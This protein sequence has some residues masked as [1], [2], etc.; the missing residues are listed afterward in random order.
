M[1]YTAGIAQ[2]D[3]TLARWQQRV[4]AGGLVGRFA[5]R[6]AQ[7]VESL[8]SDFVRRTAGSALVKERGERL[9][10]LQDH[11]LSLATRL[12]KQQIAALEASVLYSFKRDLLQLLRSAPAP[13]SSSPAAPGNGVA[14]IGGEEKDAQDQALR[15]ALFEFKSKAAELESDLLGQAGPAAAAEEQRRLAELAEV[16]ETARREFPESAVAKLE[17]MRKLER[18]A[19][20]GGG[21]GTGRRGRGLGKARGIRPSKGTAQAKGSKPGLLRLLPFT[22]SPRITNVALNLV[23]MLRPPGLGNLQGFVGYA[24]SLL[25]LPLEIMLGVQNDGDSP[26]IMGE[27]REYPILRVQPKVHF[28]VDI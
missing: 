19:A 6:V 18:E 16:L 22:I 20:R 14:A 4:S 17:E 23:G 24:T 2:A 25:G 10:Q 26:E 11:A 15:K 3:S 7:L 28:D 8:R 27:D 13:L 9:R 12:Q 1:A 5:D 21:G